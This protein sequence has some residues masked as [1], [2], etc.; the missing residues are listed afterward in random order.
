MI[1]GV[2]SMNLSL[3]MAATSHPNQYVIEKCSLVQE[4]LTK[5]QRDHREANTAGMISFTYYVLKTIYTAG[6][7]RE[8]LKPLKLPNS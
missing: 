2:R 4:Q 6:R 8:R 5:D 7:V 1:I 3:I